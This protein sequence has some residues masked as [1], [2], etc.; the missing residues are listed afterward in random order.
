MRCRAAS[1]LILPAPTRRTPRPT[2][3]A[4]IFLASSTAANETDTACR[5]ISVSVRTFFATA[6]ACVNSVWRAG[7]I[8]SHDWARANASFTCPRICGSPSIIESRRAMLSAVLAREK[9]PSAQRERESGESQDGEVRG[10]PPVPAAD[11]ASR[12]GCRVD[13]PGD[14]GEER[15]RIEGEDATP[16]GPGPQDAE[17]QPRGEERKAERERAI[18]EVIEGRERRQR[19]VQGARALGPELSLLEQVHQRAGEV[20]DEGRDSH[21]S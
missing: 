5:A 13:R 4:K 15:Q 21:E 10:A 1:S 18:G 12:E 17:E 11:G 3:P 19:V 20:E 2:S 14:E 9:Q 8:V 7:P 16:G 6:K